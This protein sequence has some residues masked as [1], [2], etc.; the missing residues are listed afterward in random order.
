M[1]I[2]SAQKESASSAFGQPMEWNQRGLECP[3]CCTVVERLT[4]SS[5][6]ART[7]N[8]ERT[9]LAARVDW[10]QATD[11]ILHPDGNAGPL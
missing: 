4:S 2:E 10:L 7:A 6:Y 8:F 3:G 5:A 11:D 9:D 1:H